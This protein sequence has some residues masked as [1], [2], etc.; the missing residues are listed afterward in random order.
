MAIQL[1]VP[2][3][4]DNYDK[5]KWVALV[6]T[7]GKKYLVDRVMLMTVSKL[8][9][10]L[11][12]NASDEESIPLDNPHCTD[13]SVASFAT[14]L[15]HHSDP[16]S[17]M[18]RI[19]YPLPAGDLS[20]VFPLWDLEFIHEH[21]VPGGDMKNHKDLYMLAGLSVYLGVTTLQEMCCAYFAWHIRD[22]TEKAKDE[23]AP[24]ATTVVR[25]WFGLTGDFTEAEMKELVEKFRWTR[26]VDYN[27]LEK[28]C[29]EAHERIVKKRQE[30]ASA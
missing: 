30:T 6:T 4:T 29:D 25:S 3:D 14:W 12:E 24:S 27:Q 16:T 10:G 17:V 26:E 18:T 22:I 13:K 11:L 28:D 20:V 5:S 8:A 2:Q 23:G 7:T 19:T 9:Q 15:N 21:L 1:A